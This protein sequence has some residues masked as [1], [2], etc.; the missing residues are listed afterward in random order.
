MA[1][2]RVS[3]P[4]FYMDIGLFARH[5]GI[6]TFDFVEYEPYFKLNPAKSKSLTLSGSSGNTG[7]AGFV[8]KLPIGWV[9]TLQYM[10][11]LGHK[12]FDIPDFKFQIK[13]DFNSTDSFD[14]ITS[15]STVNC[16]P[17][18][19]YFTAPANGYSLIRFKN[20]SEQNNQVK[21]NFAGNGGTTFNIGDVSAGWIFEMP[22]SPDLSLKLSYQNES[23]STQTTKGGHSLSNSGWSEAPD[24]LGLPQWMTQD[25]A[26]GIT[27]FK[28]MMPSTRR[29][30]DLSFSFLNDTD[31]LN[32]KYPGD[33][34]GQKGIM[35]G[36]KP[37]FG[38][39]TF[40]FNGIKDNFFSKC[41]MG[42]ANGKLPFIFQPDK[43]VDEFAICK[44]NTDS[45][46]L[47]QVANNVYDVSVSLT[48]IW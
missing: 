32:N 8:L 18:G 2:Q 41:W 40:K 44:F 22:H 6:A 27:N 31:L 5:H 25:P 1:Y 24:W 35:Q 20:P 38:D 45:F 7:Y 13:T 17:T 12:F 23:I 4:K 29:S 15:V 33:T 43:D 46:T 47:N 39:D 3:T 37:L 34:R 26:D 19:D 30:W 36:F 16:S 9:N 48:E 14:Y 10:A 21:I 28:G 11:V 42:S